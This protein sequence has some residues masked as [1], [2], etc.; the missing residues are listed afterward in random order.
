MFLIC[1]YRSKRF[2]SYLVRQAKQD[3]NSCWGITSPL[4]FPNGLHVPHSSHSIFI[5]P[6]RTFPLHPN[7]KRRH[8]PH[9]T[10]TKYPWFQFWCFTRRSNKQRVVRSRR[11][12]LFISW[13]CILLLLLILARNRYLCPRFSTQQ[14]LLSLC[15]LG[16][17]RKAEAAAFVRRHRLRVALSFG[18]KVLLVSTPSG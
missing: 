13:W 5:V 6:Q 8:I 12:H 7:R 4:A 11:V 1:T 15:S 2:F 9:S 3:C 18:V 16:Y 14:T 10:Y 17:H